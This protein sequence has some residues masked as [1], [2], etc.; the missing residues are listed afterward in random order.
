M[1]YRFAVTLLLLILIPACQSYYHRQ[2]KFNQAFEQGNFQEAESI[3]EKSEPKQKNQLLYFLNRGISFFMQGQYEA[4]NKALEQAYLT[5]ETFQKKTGRQIASYFTNPRVTLYEGEHHEVLLINYFKALNYLFLDKPWDALV[6]CRRMNIQLQSL[7]FTYQNKRNKYQAD[8][9]I[10]LLMGLI[11][12]ANQDYNNA[13]IAYRNAY[14]VYQSDYKALFGISAPRQLKADLIRT[15]RL[16]GL[17][18]EANRYSDK[19][20]DLKVSKTKPSS[21]SHGTLVF[22]WHNGLGPVKDQN[23]FNFTLV[24]NANGGAASFQNERYGWTIPYPNYQNDKEEHDDLPEIELLRLALPKYLKRPPY[25][26]SGHLKV[27]D[28]QYNL[29]VVENITKIS[30]QVLE[31]RLLRDLGKALARLAVKEATEYAVKEES[32]GWGSLVDITNFITEQADTRNW[33]TLPHAIHY[34]KVPLK[35]G[36]QTVQLKLKTPQGNTKTY[37]FT[38]DLKQ[39]EMHFEHFH[40]LNTRK[41]EHYQPQSL[42]KNYKP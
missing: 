34:A 26:Q 13:F 30:F 33:Q 31:D 42:P 20:A 8:A 38:Y 17:N 29:P 14:E 4:S 19:F 21:S 5:A 15:A 12:E 25:F 2:E 7:N 16:S 35:A 40:T 10:N 37:D 36:Q 39:G 3:L 23:T 18:N 27:E 1:A 24:E 41:R 11:Y 9:F 22:L 28:R 32:E 6:E